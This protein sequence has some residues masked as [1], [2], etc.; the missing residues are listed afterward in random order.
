MC[1]KSFAQRGNV[2]AHK[3]VH[4]QIKPFTCKL[5]DCGKQFTQLGNLKVCGSSGTVSCTCI[6]TDRFQVSSKQ[7][8][9][10]HTSISYAKVRPH[11]GG[12]LCYHPGQG[13]L[14]VF[15]FVVQ[16]LQQGYQR[17]GQ[18][19]QDLDCSFFE[20]FLFILCLQQPAPWQC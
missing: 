16:E 19:S 11:Q 3:I 18:G 13:A 15:C 4:Q 20:C 6:R 12:R 14:G 8:P 9:L 7:I 10:G 1:G 5:D 17:P 2:R